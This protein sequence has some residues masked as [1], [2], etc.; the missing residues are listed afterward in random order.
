MTVQ[1]TRIVKTTAL[2]VVALVASATLA[3]AQSP[4]SKGRDLLTANCANCHAVGRQGASKL[5]AAVPFRV[6]AKRYPPA[7]LAEA[8]AEGIVT[9]H[10]GMPQFTFTPEEIGNIL[11][12]LES[13]R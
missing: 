10:P 7:N 9:G 2:V 4:G 8:L 11:T 5:P 12:Y 3:R 1:M 13:L 6:I